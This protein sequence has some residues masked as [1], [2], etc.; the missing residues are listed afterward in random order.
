M[1]EE[2]L[3]KVKE[4]LQSVLT[5][6]KEIESALLNVKELKLRY[7]GAVEVLEQLQSESNDSKSDKKKE[8]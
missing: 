8:K 3:N 2:K 6:E 5:K 7:I 4:E 1:V